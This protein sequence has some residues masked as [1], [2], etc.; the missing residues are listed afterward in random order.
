MITVTFE[1]RQLEDPTV[2]GGQFIKTFE[3]Q[4]ALG[5][6]MQSQ[7]GHPRLHLVVVNKKH[8]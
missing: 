3:D 8:S 4:E 5:K 2:A 6:Y 1:V 7:G